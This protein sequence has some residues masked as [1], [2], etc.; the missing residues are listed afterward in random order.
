MTSF[1]NNSPPYADSPFVSVG[2]SIL[3]R[4]ASLPVWGKE[5][6]A[7]PRRRYARKGLK[8]SPVVGVKAGGDLELRALRQRLA[9][10]GEN[11][12]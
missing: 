10:A 7:L 11:L 9:R 5:C 6:G 3:N 12:D 8:S 4:A 1:S 2:Q